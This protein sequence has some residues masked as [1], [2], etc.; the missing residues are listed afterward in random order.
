MEQMLPLHDRR[1]PYRVWSA[2]S[3]TGE[4][5]FTVAMVLADALGPAGNWEVV[6]TDLSSSVVAAA[7]TGLYGMERI[8]GISQKRLQKYCLKGSG[9]YQ[10]KMLMSRELRAKVRFEQANLMDPFSPQ[11]RLG[12]FDVIFL[13]NVLIYFDLEAKQAIVGNVLKHLGPHGFFFTGHAETL[14]GVTWELAAV[15][16]AVYERAG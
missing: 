7:R 10:G 9:D 8:N 14:T 2:A 16:P 13:R 11:L 12:K 6:G 3:S 15:Q 4:E 5:A 1:R